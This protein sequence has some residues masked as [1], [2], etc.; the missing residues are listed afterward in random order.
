M[1]AKHALKTRRT[2]V[3]KPRSQDAF[4]RARLR[5]RRHDQTEV[6]EWEDDEVLG[7]DVEDRE[8]ILQLAKMTNNAYVERGDATWYNLSDVWRNV[9]VDPSS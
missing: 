7:P 4:H 6:L 1:D 2:S 3:H 9:R 8:T 5:S